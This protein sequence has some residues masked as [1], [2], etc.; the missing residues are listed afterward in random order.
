MK[1]DPTIYRE[2]LS[3]LIDQAHANG[4]DFR[5]WFQTSIRPDW[6]GS[7][8][9]IALLVSEHRYFALI[10]SHD[11]ARKFWMKGTQMSF[12]VPSLTYSRMNGKGEVET[13]NRKPFTRRT[14]KGDVW[15]YHLSQ[16]AMSEDPMR[17][18]QRFLPSHGLLL[19]RQG[20]SDRFSPTG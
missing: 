17:Y 11:F 14:V 2:M 10:F 12:L 15:K 7:D 6:P 8:Q 4:F 1:E 16:M 19:N 20:E 9:A 3:V 13:I 5:R 18:L